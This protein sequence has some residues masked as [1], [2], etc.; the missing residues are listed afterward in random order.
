MKPGR[1]GSGMNIPNSLFFLSN[2]SRPRS[3][4]TRKKPVMTRFATGILLAALMSIGGGL[5]AA[6]AQETGEKA[7][8]AAL[9]ERLQPKI[10][11]I[12]RELPDWLRKTG[13]DAAESAAET[14]LNRSRRS[15]LMTPR[16]PADSAG[17]DG[18]DRTDCRREDA[19]KKSD[20]PAVRFW[21]RAVRRLTEERW[22]E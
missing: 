8:S 2:G 19:D 14:L 10:H 17:D 15:S 4:T 21:K 7:P 9:A 1:L 22:N 16:R 13:R 6:V 12:Q 5:A 18:R 20:K 3:R 11:K